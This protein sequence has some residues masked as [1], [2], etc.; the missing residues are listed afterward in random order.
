MRM[1][2]FQTKQMPRATEPMTMWDP[3]AATEHLSKQY[4]QTQQKPCVN[5][6]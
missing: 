5:K 6:V 4:F 3:A 2:D 1:Q